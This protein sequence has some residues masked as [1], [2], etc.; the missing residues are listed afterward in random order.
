MV[1]PHR[2]AVQ[3]SLRADLILAGEIAGQPIKHD[4]TLE[5]VWGAGLVDPADEW[6]PGCATR[7]I[8]F[9]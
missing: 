8:S 5:K 3:L 6:G 9:Y 2:E 1:L 7:K 4:T